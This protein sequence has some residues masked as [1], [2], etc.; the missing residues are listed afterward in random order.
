MIN[1]NLIQAIITPVKISNTIIGYIWTEVSFYEYLH[2]IIT[3]TKQETD[4][5]EYILLKKQSDLGFILRDIEENG[6]YKIRTIPIS[7]SDKNELESFIRGKEFFKDA[8][9][10]GSK[11]FASVNDIPKYR[12]DFTCKNQ[13]G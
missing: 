10:K 13:S 3:Y 11:I 5:V 7:K 8:K 4:D 2:P 12:L 9:F 6:E 1:K